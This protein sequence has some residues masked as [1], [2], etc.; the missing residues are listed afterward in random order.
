V[1]RRESQP[2]NRAMLD[3]RQL[4]RPQR[5]HVLFGQLVCVLTAAAASASAVLA[6]VVS[7][8]SVF[9]AA[10]HAAA[11]LAAGVLAAATGFESN[12]R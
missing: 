10:N 6:V 1:R 4:D 3:N 7:S 12:G 8:A 11:V 9:A 5:K 2:A